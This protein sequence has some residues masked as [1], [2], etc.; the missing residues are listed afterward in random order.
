MKF[1]KLGGNGRDDGSYDQSKMSLILMITCLAGIIMV[2]AG[3]LMSRTYPSIVLYIGI[4]VLVIGVVLSFLD[5]RG[6][7]FKLITKARR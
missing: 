2:V 3:F 7:L 5:L 4:V 6:I 1:G